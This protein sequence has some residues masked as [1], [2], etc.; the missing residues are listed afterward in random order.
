MSAGQLSFRLSL[1]VGSIFLALGLFLP[2][3]PVFLEL[4]GMTAVEIGILLAAATWVKILGVPFWGR[5][6]D[7]SGNTRGV[8]LLLGLASLLAYLYLGLAGGFLLLLIGHIFLG[9]VY[10]PLIP[11]TDAEILSAGRRRG[12]DYGRVRLWGSVAFVAGN[13][14][15]GALLELEGGRWFLGAILASL[16]LAAGAA[17]SLPRAEKPNSDSA[18]L[19]WRLLLTNGNFLRLVLIA[20]FL[21]SSHAAYYAVSSL[22]WLAAGHS[23][24]TI[25][26][27][28]AEGVLVEIALLAVSGRLMVRTKPADLLL[29]AGAAGVLRWTVT[30]LSSDLGVLI[31]AQ[32]L[33]ALTFAAAHLGAVLLIA[34]T[35]P[36]GAAASGQAIYTALQGGI[37][38]GLAL[39]AAGFLYDIS[40]ASA[41]AA[42]AVLSGL[43]LIFGLLWHRRLALP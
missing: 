33:H 43:G 23:E 32:A 11:L 34:K 22:T 30:G 40:P 5:I 7:R 37:M 38:M 3:W 36:S 16:L 26:W 41:F 35:V 20:G 6:A 12:I 10:N 14:A 9:F 27:L 39:L 28:W 13:L 18:P 4:R 8:L 1:L 25:A 29:L 42:M 2:F 15:G 19:Q 17:A 24:T 21:Q 31:A